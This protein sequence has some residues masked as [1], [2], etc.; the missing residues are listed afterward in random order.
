MKQRSLF[1]A[2]ILS[3]L[4]S[5]ICMARAGWFSDTKTTRNAPRSE[6]ARSQARAFDPLNSQAAWRYRRGQASNWRTV[7]MYR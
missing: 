3:L 6:Q 4:F 7:M 2:T 5:G 1:L